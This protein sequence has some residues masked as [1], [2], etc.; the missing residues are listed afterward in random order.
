[1]ALET[2]IKREQ[3]RVCDYGAILGEREPS[4]ARYV[5]AGTFG[6]EDGSL[7]EKDEQPRE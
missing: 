2:L 1:M 5:L 7:G 3:G 6:M 4:G